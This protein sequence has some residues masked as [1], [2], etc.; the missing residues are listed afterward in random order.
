MQMEVLLDIRW[1]SRLHDSRETHVGAIEVG[2]EVD[3]AAGEQNA[4]VDF[5]E[6]PAFFG[7][8]PI[9]NRRDVLG[10]VLTGFWDDV[11][12]VVWS[13]HG[14]RTNLAIDTGRSDGFANRPSSDEDTFCL[15]GGAFLL[16]AEHDNCLHRSRS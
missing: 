1:G 10:F 13:V 8:V 4:E 6:Q 3:D 12:A 11:R 15:D 9:L 14:K 16:E 5:P 7:I 2:E